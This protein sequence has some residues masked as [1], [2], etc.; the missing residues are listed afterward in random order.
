MRSIFIPEHTV[1]IRILGRSRE[2][3][4][5]CKR[6]ITT[7]GVAIGD[8]AHAMEVYAKANESS[9]P[10]A[11]VRIIDVFDGMCIK[12]KSPIVTFK[13]NSDES[14]DEIKVLMER[15]LVAHLTELGKF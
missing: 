4:H 6:L 1:N 15:H 7:Y 13:Y 11:L 10:T 8:I 5:Q 9:T 2:L 3:G 12:G 14:M